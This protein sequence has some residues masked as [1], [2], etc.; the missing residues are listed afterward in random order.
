MTCRL[1]Y[2]TTPQVVARDSGVTLVIPE[3]GSNP[4]G[5]PRT[6]GGELI[7]MEKGKR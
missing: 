1:A 5:S 6:S 7:D 2:W 4:Q 3:A